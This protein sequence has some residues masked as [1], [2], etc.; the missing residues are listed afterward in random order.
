MGAGHL[1]DASTWYMAADP[2]ALDG[3]EYVYLAGAL[4]PQIET[5]ARFVVDGMSIKVRLDFGA[6]WVDHRSMV[7]NPGA[8]VS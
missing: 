6:G 3:I 1:A 5:K 7:K 2:A 4:G 8:P